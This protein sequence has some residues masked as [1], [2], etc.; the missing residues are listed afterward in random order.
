MEI[1]FDEDEDGLDKEDLAR[2]LALFKESSSLQEIVLKWLSDEHTVGL[3][4]GMNPEGKQIVLL[5]LKAGSIVVAQCVI[6]TSEVRS[7]FPNAFSFRDPNMPWNT[8]NLPDHQRQGLIDSWLDKRDER[9]GAAYNDD[10]GY[11]VISLTSA[12]E[13]AV[14]YALSAEGYVTISGLEQDFID[15]L[16]ADNPEDYKDFIWFFY[17][18]LDR[19][20]RRGWHEGF[21]ANPALK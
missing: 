11:S 21:Y 15:D 14:S 13:V 18:Y 9:I 5:M 6:D 10:L 20:T 8:G 4:A 3:C 19:A 16:A 17:D 7:S 1:E 12:M 2:A